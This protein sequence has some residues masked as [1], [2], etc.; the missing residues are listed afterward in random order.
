MSVT[1]YKRKLRDLLLSTSC[2][3]LCYNEGQN[4]YKEKSSNEEQQTYI[5]QFDNRQYK[6][7][8]T[9]SGATIVKIRAASN[10]SPRTEEKE[11][12]QQS[13]S[14]LHYPHKHIQDIQRQLFYFLIHHE[15]YDKLSFNSKEAII[16]V[17][18]E[19]K[20]DQL[21][22]F[23]YDKRLQSPLVIEELMQLM[24]FYQ[25][26]YVLNIDEGNVSLANRQRFVIQG[27]G[28]D[29]NQGKAIQKAVLEYLER[30]AAAYE[31]PESVAGTYTQ[32][33]DKAIDP[34]KFG[35]YP[36]EM[37][38][39]HQLSFYTP[40]LLM[41]WVQAASLLTKQ[42]HLVPEQMSQ[43]LLEHIENQYV[44]DSSNGCAIGNTYTEASFYSILEVVERDQFMKAWFYG[45]PLKKIEFPSDMLSIRG[46]MLYFEALN[47]DLS[48]YYLENPMNIPVV[49]CLITS[50]NQENRFYSVTGLGCHLQAQHALEAAFFEAYKSFK[51]IRKQ[52][53]T[54]LREKIA[55]IEQTQHINE[56]IEH[57]HYFLSYRSK[58]LIEEKVGGAETIPYKSLEHYSFQ[59]QDM[60]IELE[61]LLNRIKDTYSDVLIV[62][63]GNPFLHAFGL[64]CTK[65]LLLGAVPLDFTSHLI[66]QHES[67]TEQ[68]KIKK[69]NIHPLA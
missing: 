27:Y 25:G 18:Y 54:W 40:E 30:C 63:Q 31:L 28:Y 9:S 69:K 35:Y 33:S 64:S 4:F 24:M 42:I 41:K 29:F 55:H 50:Q 14:T 49:W 53:P 8:E 47:Y 11:Y 20:A 61:V 26:G 2:V 13:K 65:A 58:P 22:E 7:E 5:L 66:R 21:K 48:F 3:L 44:Y 16:T 46:K 15:R 45:R 56:V 10:S 19:A 23:S 60:S 59:H 51:D 52:D 36:D 17:S 37:T 39:K 62:D 68:I 38:Q 1:L 12:R 57:I 43:Y 32:L 6:V 34:E 67:D